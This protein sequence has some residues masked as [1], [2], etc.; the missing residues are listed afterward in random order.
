EGAAQLEVD[1]A[2]EGLA[3]AP[4][5]R[6]DEGEGQGARLLVPRLDDEGAEL[7]RA[8]RGGGARGVG[9]G[10]EGGGGGRGPRRGLGGAARHAQGREGR[11]QRPHDRGCVV[12]DRSR[13]TRATTSS[14][15]AV[16]GEGGGAAQPAT[17]R[18]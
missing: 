7:P 6:V 3:I 13:S 2:L 15:I 17:G 8:G 12:M 16:W 10:V 4:R 1:D 11:G 9:G 18:G 5:H 14:G